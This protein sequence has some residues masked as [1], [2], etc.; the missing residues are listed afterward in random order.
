MRPMKYGLLF[1]LAITMSKGFATAPRLTVAAA[2]GKLI[3]RE[4]YKLSAEL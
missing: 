2:A 1:T 3:Y 4:M